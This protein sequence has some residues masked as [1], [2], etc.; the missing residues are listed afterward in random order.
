M[1]CATPPKKPPIRAL[2]FSPR[3]GERA[4][5]PSSYLRPRSPRGST[6]PGSRARRHR[7]HHRRSARPSSSSCSTSVTEPGRDVTGG[8]ATAA[9]SADPG[10]GL[11]ERRNEDVLGE[12]PQLTSLGEL[13]LVGRAEVDPLL[14]ELRGLRHRLLALPRTPVHALLRVG[15]V[16]LHQP[17]RLREPGRAAAEHRRD[18]ADDLRVRNGRSP[19]AGARYRLLFRARA[20]A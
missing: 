15:R 5:P 4:P 1:S 6:P 8:L 12:D 9:E 11:V 14:D 17:L 10:V 13:L 3:S 18:L 20:L 7:H 2:P 16:R 19:G